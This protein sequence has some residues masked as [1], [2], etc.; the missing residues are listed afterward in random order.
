MKKIKNA[1][2][3]MVAMA[4][5]AATSISTLTAQE[6]Q[7]ADLSTLKATQAIE[8]KAGKKYK[9]TNAERQL[10]RHNSKRY[11]IEFEAPAAAVYKGGVPGYAATSTHVTG[12]E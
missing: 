9:M 11:I 7:Q 8:S 6:I 12:L 5:A 1:H 3:S 10:Q 2:W 4:V